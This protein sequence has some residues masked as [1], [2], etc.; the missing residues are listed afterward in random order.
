MTLFALR[1]LIIGRSRGCSGLRMD[2]AL[3]RPA[4]G[5]VESGGVLPEEFGADMMRKI[6]SERDD[7]AYRLLYLGV[8]DEGLGDE[9]RRYSF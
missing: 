1:C 8:R 4:A 9:T 6:A 2:P 5:P 3:G 7:I